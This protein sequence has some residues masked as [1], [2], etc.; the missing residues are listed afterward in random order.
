M[1]LAKVLGYNILLDLNGN[2]IAGTTSDTFT[3]SPVTEETIMKGDNGVK[4][5]ELIGE[6][7]KFSVNAYVI[8]S[9]DAGYM[10]VTEVMEACAD[11]DSIAFTYSFGSASNQC[12]V[13]G[14]AQ[15]LSFTI[16]SDSE[17]YSD[18]SIELQTVG[19]ITVTHNA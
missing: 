18:M 5:L 4:Q 12:K 9:S 6:E 15:F 10:D 11:N 1:A 16:N 3:L 17:S 2:K 7:G 19:A 8:K 14:T 13:T